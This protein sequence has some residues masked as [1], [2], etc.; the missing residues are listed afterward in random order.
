MH[1]FSARRLL[2]ALLM[3]TA[4]ASVSSYPRTANDLLLASSFDAPVASRGGS[5]FHWYDLDGL[6]NREPYGI[7]ARYHSSDGGVA[8]RTRVQQQLAVMHARGMR[9]LSLG[10]FFISGVS[11]GTLVDV[12]D[13]QQVA[14]SLSNIQLLLADVRAAGF[15]EVL[16]RFFPIGNISP[17]DSSFQPALVDAYWNLIEQVRPVVAAAGIAYRIDLGVELAPRDSN[18]SLLPTSERYKY[19]ANTQ[20]SGAVRTLWQ[21]YFAAY[22]RNDTV[23]FSF[24]TDTNPD[25]L[26]WR[27]RHMRYVYEGNYPYLYAVDIYPSD[28][29][30]AASKFIAFHDAMVREDSNG[31]LGWRDAGWIVAEVNYED[32][33]I[34]ADIS[35]AIAA[36]GRHVFYLTQWPLDRANALCVDPNVNAN[37]PYQWT[38][39]GGYGY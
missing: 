14:Q 17:S 32:P 28:T 23:G 15:S 8:V 16:F 29:L 30:N 18:N 31:N 39:W 21:R 19:P 25:N 7:V 36:T 33:L 11:S 24:F 6:C 22:G 5:N 1:I 13:P 37:A 20:W 9:R 4:S 27:V 35:S 3:L 12:S 10:I 2:S 34:A 26:R 38:V